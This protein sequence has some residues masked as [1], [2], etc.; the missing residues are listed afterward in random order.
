[1]R[2][3]SRNLSIAITVAGVL[4]AAIA[5]GLQIVAAHELEGSSTGTASD[6]LV[7][8]TSVLSSLQTAGGF[9]LAVGLV[10]LVWSVA[11]ERGLT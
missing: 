7:F 3:P 6:F 10:G 11:A 5:A 8:L 1:M 2:L 4:V 9:V